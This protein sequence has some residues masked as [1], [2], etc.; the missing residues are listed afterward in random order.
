MIRRTLAIALLAAAFAV[1]QQVRADSWGFSDWS[2]QY[3]SF[4]GG[5]HTDWSSYF[6]GLLDDIHE[7]LENS[8]WDWYQPP[9]YEQQPPR[10]VSV[11]EP[12]TMLLLGTG[13]VGLAAVRRRKDKDDS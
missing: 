13:I 10:D 3:S 12:G 6:S 8:D 4:L 5:S 7:W 9:V 1:P 11:P 2:S